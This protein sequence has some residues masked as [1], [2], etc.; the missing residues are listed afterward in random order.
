MKRLSSEGPTFADGTPVFNCPSVAHVDA[1][2]AQI[3]TQFRRIQIRRST[4]RG[5]VPELPAVQIARV[6]AVVPA[7]GHSR[8]MGRPKLLLPL[9][10]RTVVRCLIDTLFTAGIREIFL[11]VRED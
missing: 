5:A 3:H 7:A 6:F 10:G 9:R 8:R 4:E 11:L 2:E 1:Q